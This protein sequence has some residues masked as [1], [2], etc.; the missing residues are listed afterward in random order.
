MLTERFL[1][2]LNLETFPVTPSYMVS[3]ALMMIF[4]IYLA[5]SLTSDTHHDVM[6]PPSEQMHS[7][8]CQV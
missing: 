3:P 2:L 6:N 4:V 1:V 7:Y 5:N 8:R